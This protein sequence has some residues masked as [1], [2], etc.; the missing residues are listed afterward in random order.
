MKTKIL[1]LLEQNSRYSAADIALMLGLEEQEV[2]DSIKEM[3]KDKII[4]GYKTLINWDKVEHREVVTALIEVKVTPQRGEGFDK[5]AERIYRFSEVKAIY[6]M[7]GGFDLTVII[8][9]K[10]MKEVALFVGQKL[11]PLDAVLSTG[12]HFVLNKYKDHGVIFEE[13]KKDER[14]IVSP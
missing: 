7:S 5:I 1:E 4:C 14:M 6:L 13:I 2:V 8:E 3:E 9:G 11:A 12:T 10:T